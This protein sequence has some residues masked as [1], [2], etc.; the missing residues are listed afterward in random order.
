MEIEGGVPVWVSKPIEDKLAV[1][2]GCGK[3]KLVLRSSKWG[4]RAWILELPM[5]PGGKKTA[6]LHLPDPAK[7]PKAAPAP[8]G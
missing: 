5:E 4:G 7:M 2:A 1:P 6:P 8:K 3:V